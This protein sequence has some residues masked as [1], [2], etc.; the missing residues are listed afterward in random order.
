MTFT[1]ILPRQTIFNW[2]K[3]ACSPDHYIP[4]GPARAWK[5][6]DGKFTLIAAEAD[7]WQLVGTTPFD[8]QASCRPTLSDEFTGYDASRPATQQYSIPVRGYNGIMATYTLDGQTIYGFAG[9]DL[10]PVAYAQGCKDDGAGNCWLN[11]ISEVVSTDMGDDF[12]FVSST[13]GDVA[14]LSHVISSVRQ[15]QEGYM[16]SSNIVTKDDGY[17]YMIVEINDQYAGILRD[18]LMRTSNLADPTSWRAMNVDAS[19]NVLFNGVTQPPSGSLGAPIPCTPVGAGSLFEAVQSIQYITSKKL[20]V[21]VSQG[22]AQL[23]GDSTYVPGAYYAT[24]PDLIHWGPMARLVVTPMVPGYD[25]KTEV[26]FYPVLIDP[27]SKSRNFET[28]DSNTPVL[29]YTRGN[30]VNGGV[31]TL[32]RDIVAVPFMMR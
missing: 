28:I 21:A 14:A 7:N 26:D 30:L 8:L 19:G 31:L 18:C 27:F 17:Y 4:D 1:Q 5:R 6:A 29:I 15:Y 10:S 13:N 11:D 3:T 32:D 16:T 25:S 9:Q 22:R 23:P 12:N 2:N 20:F 24:S